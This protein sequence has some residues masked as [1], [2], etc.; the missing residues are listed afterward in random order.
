MSVYRYSSLRVL[1][2][3]MLGRAAWQLLR[4]AATADG[5]LRQAERKKREVDNERRVQ[6]AHT[7]FLCEWGTAACLKDK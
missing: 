7:V 3:R 6:R 4:R 1:G 2:M 5:T